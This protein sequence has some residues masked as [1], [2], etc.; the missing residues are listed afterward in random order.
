MAKAGDYVQ[1]HRV[2]LNPDQRA[3]G[4][5][6]ETRR[7]PLELWVKGFLL[8]DADMGQETEVRTVTGR[9]AG[10]TLATVSPSYTHSFGA[11][12]P[13]LLAIGTQARELTFGAEDE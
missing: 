10:G 5:P 6:Q 2:V 11:C 8:R 4:I 12:V 9:I 3:E 13:E 7:V 1:L